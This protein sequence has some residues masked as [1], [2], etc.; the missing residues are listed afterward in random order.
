MRVLSAA[1]SSCPMYE[2]VL[3][4]IAGRVKEGWSEWRVKDGAV[5]EIKNRLNSWWVGGT[6]AMLVRSDA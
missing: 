1:R 4:F 3:H 2:D 5:K 6:A